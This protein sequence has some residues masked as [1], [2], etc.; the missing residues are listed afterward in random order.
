MQQ[1]LNKSLEMLGN[2]ERNI[3]HVIALG[4]D[5]PAFIRADSKVKDATLS[6]IAGDLG[7]VMECITIHLAMTDRIL[8]RASRHWK[9]G[10][11][12]G[13]QGGDKGGRIAEY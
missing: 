1:E 6:M 10:E 12:E 3:S 2:N 11:R 7:P 13:R 4:E 9:E 5:A 8:K